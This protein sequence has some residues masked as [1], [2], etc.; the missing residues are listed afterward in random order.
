MTRRAIS[1][2]TAKHQYQHRYTMDHIPAWARKPC[3]GMFYAPQYASDAEWYENTIFPG[4][5]GKP[6]ADDHCE[7]RNAS[8]PLGQWLKQPAPPYAAPHMWAAHK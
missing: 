7:S 8:W 5:Q 1:L 6:R 4:E 2:D 3:N